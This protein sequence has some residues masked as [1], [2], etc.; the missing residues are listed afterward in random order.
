[1]I[2]VTWSVLMI[3]HLLNQKQDPI[4]NWPGPPRRDF[5]RF[6]NRMSPVSDSTHDHCH[7]TMSQKMSQSCRMCQMIHF[8]ICD[9]TLWHVNVANP[10]RKFRNIKIRAKMIERLTGQSNAWIAKMIGK[11][12]LVKNK[13][14]VSIKIIGDH[15]LNQS[16][17]SSFRT[18]NQLPGFR[19]K[20]F[21][22]LR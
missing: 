8:Y 9:M 20:R 14:D 10:L 1:M 22:F 6:R 16:K 7:V 3:I 12:W 17:F 5:D 19:S 13:I 21:R 11:L 18:R 15:I 4:Y 2:C